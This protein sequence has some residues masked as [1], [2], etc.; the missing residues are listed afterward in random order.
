MSEC[1][2]ES[3]SGNSGGKCEINVVYGWE[4]NV[5]MLVFF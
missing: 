2:G 3:E 5:S 1:L 4:F